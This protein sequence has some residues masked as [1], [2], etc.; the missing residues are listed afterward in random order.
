MNPKQ[1]IE[2]KTMIMWTKF[3]RKKKLWIQR[4]FKKNMKGLK[5]KIWIQNFQGLT[6]NIIKL[7]LKGKI[8]KKSKFYKRN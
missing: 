6:L 4:W 1:K 2:I 3:E 5:I 7:E 8:K